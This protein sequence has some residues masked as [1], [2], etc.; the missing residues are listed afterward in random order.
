MKR[1]M[2]EWNVDGGFTPRII[3]SGWN[4]WYLRTP[5]HWLYYQVSSTGRHAVNLIQIGT[6]HGLDPDVI[7]SHVNGMQVAIAMGGLQNR[8]F[9]LCGVRSLRALLEGIHI[10]HVWHF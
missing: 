5:L 1:L 4:C 10:G 3:N 9:R 7:T 2:D 8:S 6:G